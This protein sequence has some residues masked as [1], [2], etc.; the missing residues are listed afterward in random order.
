MCFAAAGQSAA[1]AFPELW[2]EKQQL[3]QSPGSPAAA[4][5]SV[6]LLVFLEVAVTAFKAP[7]LQ[8]V[9]STLSL[10]SLV[11]LTIACLGVHIFVLFIQYFINDTVSS[12]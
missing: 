3:R 7:L 9:G 6:C 4:A 8:G 2:E 5:G 11:L 12:V 10:P 1:Q